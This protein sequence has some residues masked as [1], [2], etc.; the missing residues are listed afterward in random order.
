MVSIAASAPTAGA[1]VNSAYDFLKFETKQ[2]ALRAISACA[3]VAISTVGVHFIVSYAVLGTL[4]SISCAIA[5]LPSAMVFAKFSFLASIQYIFERAISAFVGKVEETD[6]ASQAFLKRFLPNFISIIGSNIC[7][8]VLEQGTS[9]LSLSKILLGDDDDFDESD[10][11]DDG[12]D[13]DYTPWSYEAAFMVKYGVEVLIC[14]ANPTA[15]L[16]KK[17]ARAAFLG[18]CFA[19]QKGYT[20]ASDAYAS[21]TS[22]ASTSA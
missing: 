9:A 21:F 3:L 1:K 19:A 11:I 14:V 15:F 17:A 22:K 6:S 2:I 12:M 16:V 20:A 13:T 8:N 18:I 7:M 5:S 10:T 4:P